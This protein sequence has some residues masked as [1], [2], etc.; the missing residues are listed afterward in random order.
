MQCKKEYREICTLCLV[1][2]VGKI[3]VTA[4]HYHNQE[5]DIDT[6]YQLYSDFTQL[7]VCV[8]VCI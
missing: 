1:P 4:E 7:C 8:C 6:V 5:T 3:C 2:P